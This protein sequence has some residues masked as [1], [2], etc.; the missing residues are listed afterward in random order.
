MVELCREAGRLVAETAGPRRRVHLRSGDTAL[1]IEWA[2]PPP[3][4]AGQ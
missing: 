4:G 1:E 3:V 2:D